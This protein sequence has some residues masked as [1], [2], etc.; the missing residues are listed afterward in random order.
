MDEL[1]KPDP[2]KLPRNSWVSCS[3]EN[4][5]RLSAV[6]FYFARTL[7]W[8]LKV[9]IGIV[10][11]SL[12]GTHAHTW[13]NSKTIRSTAGATEL[14]AN[15]DNQVKDYESGETYRNNLARWEKHV[16]DANAKGQKAPP[17]PEKGHNNPIRGRNHIGNMFNTT[18]V[19]IQRLAIR[20]VLY[21]QGENDALSGTHKYLHALFPKL[22]ADW[23][24]AF[25][26]PKL[27]FGVV[28]MHGTRLFNSPTMPK[29]P[30]VRDAH[31]LGHLKNLDTDLIMGCDMGDTGLHPKP[32]RGIGERSA[33][34]ALQCLYGQRVDYIAP[35]V[36]CV[37]TKDGKMIVHFKSD[38]KYHKWQKEWTLDVKQQHA[39]PARGSGKGW[40]LR[41]F[42][43]AATDK[44]FVKAKAQLVSKGPVF[45]V[46]V[47]SETIAEPVAVRYG[48]QVWPD[49]N[50]TAVL[51]WEPGP[52][53]PVHPFRTDDWPLE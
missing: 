18:V 1:D 4:A 13:M 21:Y 14:V 9:P 10:N 22:I 27:P 17:K 28:S 30:K 45:A 38:P 36:D 12:G 44:K 42:I 25:N 50:L 37:E 34:W 15:Q 46:E 32:K 41:G 2:K 43:I 48:W 52:A 11:P 24:R 31:M 20:G 29:W 3:P 19:P 7:Y 33:R 47:W 49:A 40:P 16:A 5:G 23:R 53:T 39:D 35:L 51:R 26:D 8:N 6:P